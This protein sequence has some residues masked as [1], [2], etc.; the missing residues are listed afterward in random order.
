ML[1]SPGQ[2]WKEKYVLQP[3]VVGL[4]RSGAGLH[5]KV[6]RR[7]ATGDEAPLWAGP[8][9]GCDPRPGPDRDAPGTVLAATVGEAAR[10]VRDP[11]RT[12][13]HVCTPPRNRIPLLTE[14]ADSGFRR[15]VVEKPLAADLPELDALLALRDRSGLRIAPVAHWL[16]AELT[17]R[18]RRIVH[19]EP[20][21]PL[22]RITVDQ[23]KPRFARSLAT[24]GHPTALDVE[25]PHS[26][27]LALHLAGPARL[28]DAACADLRA[29][30][31]VRPLLGGARVE[32]AH[33]GGVHTTLRS[34]LMSPVRQRTAT[35]RFRDGEVTAHYPLSEEDDHAQL[36]LP[37]DPYGPRS[38]R[39][40]AL[41]A[42]VRRTYEEFA[43]DRHSP[44]FAVA[45]ETTRLL[46]DARERC[47][48]AR[49]FGRGAA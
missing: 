12:V 9:I 47:R 46:C 35:L 21:G 26:L 29:G 13:V 20:F 2:P 10:H 43:A 6:L 33:G 45:C 24:S 11:E 31:E 1:G 23:H 17:A 36:A 19:E 3:L 48:T 28:A 22:R 27:G 4:G 15:L 16:T 14:L 41:S 39:D 49:P 30:T 18:L 8:L 37:G 40:D 38:F 34:D 44:D 7:L 42:F 5:M 25:I 32:L